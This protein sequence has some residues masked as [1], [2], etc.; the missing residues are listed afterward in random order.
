MSE[1]NDPGRKERF[2][3]LEPK[4]PNTTLPG[5]EAW[6]VVELLVRERFTMLEPKG[7]NTTLPGSEAWPVIEPIINGYP[8]G[9]EPAVVMPPA[10]QTSLAQLADALGTLDPSARAAAINY[11]VA[12]LT[13]RA[14]G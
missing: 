8:T 2:T 10:V 12:E 13:K 4:G 9:S 5:S 6:P 11:I 14:A 1:N 7:P 3:M